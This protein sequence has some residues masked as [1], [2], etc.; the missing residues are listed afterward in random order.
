MQ[1]ASAYVEKGA[2]LTFSSTREE[3]KS[4]SRSLMH[5]WKNRLSPSKGVVLC[6]AGSCYLHCAVKHPTLPV[7]VI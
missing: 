2:R 3:D 4:A 1:E 5:S 6:Y 7:K